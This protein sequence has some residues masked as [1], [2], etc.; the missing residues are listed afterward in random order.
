MIPTLDRFFSLIEDGVSVKDW[1]SQMPRGLYQKELQRANIISKRKEKMEHSYSRTFFKADYPNFN[2]ARKLASFKSKIR[3]IF[4]S[5][6]L[7]YTL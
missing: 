7:F 6:C 3:K 4:N 5:V 2:E 1:F